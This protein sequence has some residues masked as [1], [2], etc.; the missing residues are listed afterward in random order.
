MRKFYSLCIALIIFGFL[1]TGCNQEA[2]SPGTLEFYSYGGDR[3]FVGMVS[4]DGWKIVF[5][6]FYVTMKDITSYQ[7]DPPYDPIYSADIIRYE[8][9]VS[10]DGTY[11]TDIAQGEGRRL[12]GAVT[13]APAGLY[14]A[15]SWYYTPAVEGTPA[16]YSVFIIGKAGKDDQILD[17]TLKLNLE[18]GYQCGNYF[19][20]TRDHAD[21]IGELASGG[22]AEMEM[23]YA[24]EMLF[25]DGG[26]SESSIMNRMAMGFQPIAAL[27]ENS[28]IDEDLASLKQKLSA[29]DYALF[30]SGIPELGKVGEGR[31]YYFE[32]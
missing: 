1:C 32:P 3:V 22:K 8:T 19:D 6:H 2:D 30:T 14:N 20:S 11:T 18:G 7:T 24:V 23:T 27:A 5:N 29:E 4:K 26:Q 28:I 25:G 13:D 17:F 31:C 10:L 16:G 15:V 21:F 9:S 12:V